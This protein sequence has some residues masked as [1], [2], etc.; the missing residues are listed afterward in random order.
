MA[1]PTILDYLLASFSPAMP[2]GDPSAATDPNDAEN[3]DDDDE[4]PGRSYVQR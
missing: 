2:E 4:G 3:L 1:Y